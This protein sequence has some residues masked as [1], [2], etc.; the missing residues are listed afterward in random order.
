[1]PLNEE[2][3]D[4]IGRYGTFT[5]TNEFDYFVAFT[6][7]NADGYTV[8]GNA[9]V[10]VNG[11]PIRSYAD[12]KDVADLIARD[13][14]LTDVV[15]LSWQALAEGPDK[16]AGHVLAAAPNPLPIEVDE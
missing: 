7:R 16:P 13:Y 4:L 10:K 11:R 14:A 2:L 6:C 12:T 9:G 15:V 3:P 8:H 5:P 1:M